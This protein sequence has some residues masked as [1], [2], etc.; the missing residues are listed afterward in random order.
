MEDFESVRPTRT[1]SE[2][3]L[4]HLTA[5]CRPNTVGRQI[6]F[7]GR[8]FRPTNRTLSAHGTGCALLFGPLVVDEL[9]IAVV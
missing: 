7:T 3:K 6:F 2:K 9:L 8:T 4:Q 1:D 5:I